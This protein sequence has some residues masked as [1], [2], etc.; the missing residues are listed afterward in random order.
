MSLGVMRLHSF[1]RSHHKAEAGI[2][3]YY[4][5]KLLEGKHYNVV[6]SHVAKK[7]IR[8]IFHFMRTGEL[9]KEVVYT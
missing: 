9:Y 8:V 6:L 4:E 2:K 1:V 7:L 3:A 5:K